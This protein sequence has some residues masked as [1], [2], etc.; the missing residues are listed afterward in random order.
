MV[1]VADLSTSSL[2]PSLQQQA[3]SGKYPQ[4]DQFKAETQVDRV[5]GIEAD[6]EGPK[7]IV[8]EQEGEYGFETYKP[9]GKLIG[10]KTIVTGGDS[11]IGRA[12]A[13]MYAMEGAD[14]AIVYLPEEE[15]DAQETKRLIEQNG[16]QALL[17][18]QD[19][20]EE[21]GCNR[22][23]DTVIREF[24]AIDVLVNNASVMYAQES[25]NDITTEQC[26]CRRR[27]PLLHCA[28]TDPSHPRVKST[29]PSTPILR[30]PSTSLVPPSPT[31]NPERPS[32]SP[33]RRLPTLDLPICSTTR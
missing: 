31:L 29:E 21:E 22:I 17:I 3:P 9:A 33:R 2:P 14:V 1:P 15:V 20:R 7:P 18:P 13:V 25:I 8:T 6:I 23:V 5:V 27:S 28:E 12:V 24:G 26:A 19:I 11:G 16:Q 10:K 30:V 32:S 4:P